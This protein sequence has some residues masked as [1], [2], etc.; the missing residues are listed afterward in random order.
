[1]CDWVA[2]VDLLQRW[3][4]LFTSCLWA[5][6]VPV[7]TC[8]TVCLNGAHVGDNTCDTRVFY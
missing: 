1:M 6:V 4:F 7:T 2:A 3:Y 5:N 8:W